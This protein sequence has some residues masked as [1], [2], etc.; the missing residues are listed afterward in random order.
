[1]PTVY[2]Y[3]ARVVAVHDGDTLTLDIDLGLRIWAI[4]QVVRLAGIN[5]PEL[6]GASRVAGIAARDWL[7]ERVMFREVLLR[8]EKPD[9]REK[10]GRWLGWIVCEGWDVNRLMIEHGHAQAYG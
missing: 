5:A 2:E 10:Y 1:M 8:T 7:R 4:K 3:R 9:S 6:S